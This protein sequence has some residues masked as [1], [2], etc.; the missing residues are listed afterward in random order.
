MS[1]ETYDVVIIGAG[2]AGAILAKTLSNAGNSVL[3]LEAGEGLHGIDLEGEEAR[4]VYQSYLDTFYKAEAK[5]PN[6]PYPNLPTAPSPDVLDIHAVEG[7][8]PSTDGYF[9]QA[10]P[11]PFASDYARTPGGTTLHWLGTCLRML[12]NDF[13]INKMYG[14]GVDWPISY[15]ELRPYYEMAEHEIGVSG[16][17]KDLYYPNAGSNFFGEFEYPMHGLPQSYL[18]RQF[19]SAVEGLKSTVSD[20]AG[21]TERIAVRVTPTPQGRNSTPNARYRR[22]GLRWDDKSQKLVWEALPRVETYNPVGATWD[23]YTGQRCEGNANCVPIC[24]VQA[25][26]NALKTFKSA[27]RERMTIVHRA[28]AFEVDVEGGRGQ[29]GRPVTG[30][31]YKRYQ[32]PSRSDYEVKTA[33]G[34]RYVLAANSIEN[35]KLLLASGIANSSDLVGR[36]LMDHVTLLTWGLAKE[37]V[38]PYRGPG[39]TSNMP[40]F[41]DAKFRR[42]HAAFIVPLDNW[43]WS[44]PKF[45]PGSDLDDAVGTKNLFGSELRNYLEEILTRQVFLHFECEQLPEPSNRVT[46]DDKYRDKLGNHRPV[47]HY[48]ISNYLRKAFARCKKIS[49]EL[50]QHAGVKDRTSY[51]PKDSCFFTYDGQG[52]FF[53][54]AGHL[55]GTHRMGASHEDSVVDRSQRTWDHP[56]LFLVGCGNM[57][58]LGTSNPTLTMA[59]LA[60]WAAENIL[61]DLSEGKQ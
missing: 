30:I 27:A 3:I 54:G 53:R 39:S 51:D 5:V 26:Y 58:T 16:D 25:K 15:E 19:S 56:N 11:M 9:I 32:D 6:S 21:G 2:I 10:G 1:D 31:K 36:N 8:T 33:R 17:V 37:P 29:I 12:P 7:I 22:K 28:V 45:S 13:R 61:K 57:P 24:P 55:V 23:T 48:D 14:V 44:W 60:F 47:I 38:Y 4:Q 18:D 20:G 41:R 40:V 35:A 46:I 50:F 34:K 49:D 52:Y 43:G 59:A 42:E